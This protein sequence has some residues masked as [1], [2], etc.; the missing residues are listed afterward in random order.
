MIIKG[1]SRGRARDLARHLLRTDQNETVRL[2]E[3]RGTVARDVEGALREMEAL[4]LASRTSK[5]LY[6]ASISPEK[7]LPLTD[8]QVS[9]AVDVLERKLGLANQPRLIVL[10][11]KEGRDHVH[12]VW[13]RIDIARGRAIA[14][15]WNYRGHEEAARE[16]EAAFGHPA[17]PGPHLAHRRRRG[18]TRTGK[19]YEYRQGER[20][21]RPAAR[22]AVEI[23]AL[24]NA[25]PDGPGF[26]SSLEE[27]GYTLARGDRRVFVVIDRAGNVHSLARRLGLH[28]RDLRARLPGLDL[29]SLPSVS[30]ARP[31]NRKR[32]RSVRTLTEYGAAARAT[33]RPHPA[34][35]TMPGR[36]VMPGGPGRGTKIP[37]GQIAWINSAAHDAGRPARIVAKRFPVRRAARRYHS[38]R[39]IILAAFAARIADALRYGTPDRRDAIV[40]ALLAERAASLRA[41]AE[42]S[43]GAAWDR[44]TGNPR[45]RPR[46]VRRR[47]RLRR[48][49]LRRRNA[50]N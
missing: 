44:R 13:S 1:A 33:V 41:L 21:G 18:R 9:V 31:S 7:H 12:V 26:R 3:C 6:H 8:R 36:L 2:F 40:E 34:V 28:S 35:P 23:K 25:S 15:G 43:R 11:R 47:F 17:V 49:T 20:S 16:L 48:R 38:D 46:G 14:D 4:G 19:E 24:W 30:E 42:R 27:A 22:V 50:P 37:T 29:D 5:P 10:H 45:Q 32:S 39:A